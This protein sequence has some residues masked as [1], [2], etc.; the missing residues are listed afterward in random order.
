MRSCREHGK[1]KRIIAMLQTIKQQ[2]AHCEQI[3]GCCS[4][5][6]SS[7]GS[8]SPSFLRLILFG[9]VGPPVPSTPARRVIMPTHCASTTHS[10]GWYLLSAILIIAFTHFF[11]LRRP[12]KTFFC[13][14]LCACTFHPIH[15][16]SRKRDHLQ[17]RAEN[18]N[19]SKLQWN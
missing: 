16:R 19:S 2:P 9:V 15:C 14:F 8:C 11:S 10:A 7:V 3:F 5:L 1:H 6:M 17:Q 4:I 12:G 13:T 18:D